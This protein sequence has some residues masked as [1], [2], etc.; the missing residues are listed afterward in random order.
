[1]LERACP[2]VEKWRR[3]LLL[4][5]ARRYPPNVRSIF[6]NGAVAGK[7]SG[8]RHVQDGHP[9]PGVRVGIK[10][11][12]PLVRLKVALQVRQVHVE[13]SACEERLPQRFEGAW[14]VTAKVVG[15]D[16]VQSRSRLR[17]MIIV[18]ARAVPT[19]A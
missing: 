18:P 4:H 1:L 3:A 12:E 2:R 17:L 16:E 13:V 14:L 6:S 7:F 19:A 9:R 11:R 15:E 10:L 8:A 5:W